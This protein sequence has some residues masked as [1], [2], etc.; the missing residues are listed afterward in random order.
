MTIAGTIS[1]IK[2]G[3]IKIAG[4]IA[5][6]IFLFSCAGDPVRTDP[7]HMTV[8]TEQISRGNLAYKQGCYAA[9]MKSYY[10][11]CELYSAS[12]QTAGVAMSLNNIGNVYRAMGEPAGALKYF[13]EAGTLYAR[14][15]EQQGLRQVLANRA[16]A[17]IDLGRLDQADAVLAQAEKLDLPDKSGFLPLIIDRGILLTRRGDLNA[18]EKM[19]DTAL[20][21]PQA[22]EPD[23][24]AAHY[25]MGRLKME[26]GQFKTAS[27]YFQAALKADQ[28]AGFYA[29]MADDLQRLGDA[30]SRLREPD[31][32]LDYWKRA[33]RIYALIGNNLETGAVVK[34]LQAEAA[35]TGANLEVIEAF[36]KN[37]RENRNRDRLCN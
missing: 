8:G 27:G 30:H 31:A 6:V 2:S 20:A 4:L 25:A 22:G 3:L 21:K 24:A 32:A 35:R 5:A 14:S 12:D 7:P 15:G 9:A 28:A 10:R 16:A 37:C 36:V 23:A 1:G 34:K 17:L 33:V 11:A 18:A 26:M 29:G 13:E 19:L